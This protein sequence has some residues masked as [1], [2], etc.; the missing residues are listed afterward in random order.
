MKLPLEDI[1]LNGEILK[2]YN[3]KMPNKPETNV[4]NK[5]KNR[6]SSKGYP[7]K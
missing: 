4:G 3:D 7:R 1:I 2:A 5:I 6:I